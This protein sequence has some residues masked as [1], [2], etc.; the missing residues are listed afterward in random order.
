MSHEPTGADRV[1]IPFRAPFATAAGTWHA[2]DAWILRIRDADGRE[3]LGE[4]NLDP[5]ADER[6][7]ERLAAAVRRWLTTGDVEPEGAEGLAVAAAVDAALVDVGAIV[8]DAGAV[9]ASVAVNATIATEDRAASVAAAGNAVARG[10]TTLKLKGGRERSEVDLV[11][12]LAAVRGAVGG[13]IA[14]RLDVNGAW[15]A[16]TARERLG[17]LAPLGLEYVEQPIAPGDPAALAR[18]RADSPVRIA[19]DESVDSLLAA[20]DLLAAGAVDVLVVKPG[21]V[22]GPL[23]ALA[24]AREA[25]AAGV[26]VTIST[27]LDTGVGLTAALRTAACLPNGVHGLATADILASDLLA[28]PLHVVGGRMIVPAN[29]GTALDASS[30]ERYAVERSSVERY[31]S[32]R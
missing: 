24:I 23:F 22:G 21:R 28:R 25:A 31:G 32:D 10:F 9:V 26:G 11:E 2:R 30:V 17:A 27:L 4:A 1:R 14:L 15:D 8:L 13:D 3:G 6:V 29:G 7:L 16:T 18:L 12:R 20:R 5:G 19:A